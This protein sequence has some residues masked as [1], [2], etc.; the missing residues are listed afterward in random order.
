M[1]DGRV[2]LALRCPECQ[3]WRSGTFAAERVR[4][5]HRALV[6]GRADLKAVYGRIV[7]DNMYREL[8]SFRIALELDLI[9]PDDF[10]AAA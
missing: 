7:R 10:R 4:E 9:G 2:S 3:T 1:P 8:E 6:D 5:L